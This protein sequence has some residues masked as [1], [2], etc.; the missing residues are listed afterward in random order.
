MQ[1]FKSAFINEIEKI[2]KRKKIVVAIILSV[3]VIIFGQLIVSG[4]GLGLGIRMTNSSDFPVVVLSFFAGFILPLFTVMVTID[5][6]AGEYN[7]NTMKLSLLRPISRF[8]L[9]S[10]KITAIAF[11]ALF[12]LFVFLILSSIFGLIFNASYYTVFSVLRLLLAYIVTILPI[13]CFVLVTV[14][15]CHSLKN[16]TGIFFLLVLIYI[17]FNVISA[18]VPQISSLL[19]T[20]DLSWY[21]LF[22]I[23]Q[24]PLLKILRVF[25][26]LSGYIIMLFSAGYYMFE[27]KMH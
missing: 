25:L 23:N 3:V 8:K 6:F 10:A 14:I 7:A 27:K 22:L 13:M 4:V 12:N 11:F 5:V 26:I 17:V 9:F 21:N 1:P 18:F 19:I 20:Y 15:L 16:G 24:I 2:F